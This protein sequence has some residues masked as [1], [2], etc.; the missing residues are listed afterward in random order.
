M[1]DALSEAAYR[2]AY[3]I[4][5]ISK[6]KEDLGYG[7][8]SLPFSLRSQKKEIHHEILKLSLPYSQATYI[9]K[10]ILEEIW[11]AWRL[12]R[13]RGFDE[14]ELCEHPGIKNGACLGCGRE[15]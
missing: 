2:K 13:E 10:L 7:D 3:L 4:K 12:G 9:E 11:L 14:L 5:L 6:F 1:T 8:Q 15:V